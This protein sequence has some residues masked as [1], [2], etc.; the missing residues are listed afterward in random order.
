M[1][2]TIEHKVTRLAHVSLKDSARFC[3]LFD[4]FVLLFWTSVLQRLYDEFVTVVD[5]PVV[6]ALD[7]AK[8]RNNGL[9]R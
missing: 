8:E 5:S 1:P 6:Y 4:Y 2:A 9:T 7:N 3:M